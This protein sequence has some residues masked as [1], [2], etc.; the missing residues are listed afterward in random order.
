MANG[1]TPLGAA[2]PR[3]I[4]VTASVAVS[5]NEFVEIDGTDGQLD[6]IGAANTGRI[7]VALADAASGEAVSVAIGGI[8]K[9]TNDSGGV[10]IIGTAVCAKAADTVDAGTTG[11][12]YLGTVVGP[13]GSN[14]DGAEVHVELDGALG[15][16]T[17]A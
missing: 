17:V 7:G 2:P 13:L 11:D 6:A 15:L 8:F 16:G 10:L 1:V 12:Q 4:P 14:A 5:H 3:T 9:C